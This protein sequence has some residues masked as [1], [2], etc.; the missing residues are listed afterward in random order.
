MK[1]AHTFLSFSAVVVI[2][3]SAKDNINNVKIFIFCWCNQTTFPIYIKKQTETA[4][5][6]S[7]EKSRKFCSVRVRGHHGSLDE[8]WE[9]RALLPQKGYLPL[10]HTCARGEGELTP[11]EG[12]CSPIAIFNI[13]D[14]DQGCNCNSVIP[15]LE[16]VFLPA[17]K[18]ISCSLP[19]PPSWKFD[20]SP[21]QFPPHQKN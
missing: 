6:L 2:I 21:P 13:P 3:K 20:F 16:F 14:R 17:L 12:R 4:K 8:S 19:Y 5:I 7:L 1:K 11:S 10:D 9:G 18:K 15:S